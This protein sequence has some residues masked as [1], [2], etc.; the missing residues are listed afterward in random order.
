MS[1]IVVTR[2]VDLEKEHLPTVTVLFLWMISH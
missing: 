2:A 1:T